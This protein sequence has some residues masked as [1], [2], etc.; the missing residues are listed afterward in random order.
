MLTLTLEE[1]TKAHRVSLDSL[2]ADAGGISP[3]AKMLNRPYQTVKGWDER[4]RISKKGAALVH[5]HM[6]LGEYHTVAMLRPDV[7]Q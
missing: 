1:L 7:E 6:S 4:G 2:L 5:E 3:L